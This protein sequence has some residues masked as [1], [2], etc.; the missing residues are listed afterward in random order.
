MERVAAV[1]VRRAEALLGGQHVGAGQVPAQLLGDELGRVR[2]AGARGDGGADAGDE[3][4]QLAAG[5]VWVAVMAVSVAAID[6]Y[7]QCQLSC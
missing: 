5:A 1:A 2:P 4:A 3:L 6:S 7:V